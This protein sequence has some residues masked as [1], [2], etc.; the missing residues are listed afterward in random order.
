MS[1]RKNDDALVLAAEPRVNLL[2]PEIAAQAA[3]RLLRNKLLAAT[4]GV[5]VLVIVG[6]GGASLYATASAQKLVTA[7]T[8][9]S[10]LLAEQRE[11]VVVRQIETQVNTALAARAVAGWPEVDW[12]EYLAGVDA[13]LPST[14]RLTS[15]TVDTTSPLA[16]Y[17]QPTAPLQYGRIATLGLTLASP[18][19]PPV[20][21]WLEALGTMPG[22]ADAVAGSLTITDSG[23]YIVVVTIHLNV[24]ALSGRFTDPTGG[25]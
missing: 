13:V 15:A 11:Y 18:G 2:P 10:N 19:L 1:L 9:T 23:G 21:E 4:A 25:N 12:Q 20:P 22:V 7:Q 3:D 17:A 5:I 8:E 14:V 24:D 6:I 16:L